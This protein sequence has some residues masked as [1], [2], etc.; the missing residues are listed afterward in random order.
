MK[1]GQIINALQQ[2]HRLS[3]SIQRHLENFREYKCFDNNEELATQE[4][5]LAREEEKELGKFLDT[6]I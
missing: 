3:W 6:E 2:Y 4:L 5:Q 1:I